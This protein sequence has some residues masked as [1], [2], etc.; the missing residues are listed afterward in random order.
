[1]SASA[2]PSRSRF[3][4]GDSLRAVAALGVFASHLGYSILTAGLNR[5]STLSLN[6][7]FTD[8][9]AALFN[10]AALGLFI[11]FA[12]SG[13]LIA[14]PFI[15][16]V[17]SARP[18][19]RVP[20]YL[21]NRTLRIVPAFW[22][23]LTVLV[24]VIGTG[25]GPLSRVSLPGD[26]GSS[27]SQIASLYGFAQFTTSSP[28][29]VN[30][31]PQAWTL[32]VEAVFYLAVPLFFVPLGLLA[33]RLSPAQR[34]GAVGCVIG[35]GCGASLVL[36]TQHNIFQGHPSLLGP[37]SPAWY[38]W[39]FAPGLAL[40]LAEAA[41]APDLLRRSSRA[42][43]WIPRLLLVLAAASFAWYAIAFGDGPPGGARSLG[44]LLLILGFG[45]G[46]VGAPLVREGAGSGAYRPLVS[47]SMTWVGKRS[48][49]LYLVHA[50]VVF[51]LGS[52]ALDLT[53]SSYLAVLSLLVMALPLCLLLAHLSYELV[54]RPFLRL[55]TK[56]Y[57]RQAGA[58]GSLPL[59][60]RHGAAQSG[61]SP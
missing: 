1:M 36:T 26:E 43:R 18:S 9:G 28:A 49:S 38:M 55:R 39:A 60:P 7:R 51:Q 23:I 33:R 34:V 44:V 3:E 14:A 54:E 13:Y 40:A 8:L 37:V 59:S 4:A 20:D 5:G 31:V 10:S 53:D 47:R 17:V 16:A 41:G 21:V 22:A 56:P 12:L 32:D 48:Y 42:G 27:L 50:A 30:L 2:S 15:R 19:P 29:Q 45:L 35:A 57:G 52:V 58:A 11:F 46:A 61:G 6:G 24:L 25:A